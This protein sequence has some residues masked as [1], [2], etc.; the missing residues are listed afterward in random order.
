M[1]S[2][3]SATAQGVRRVS[4]LTIWGV[5]WPCWQGLGFIMGQRLEFV[6][7]HLYWA[8]FIYLFWRVDN[9]SIPYWQTR[10]TNNTSSIFIE[11]LVLIQFCLVIPCWTNICGFGFFIFF[12]TPKNCLVE[13]ASYMSV[14]VSV[15]S[16]VLTCGRFLYANHECWYICMYKES[17]PTLPNPPFLKFGTYL[18]SPGFISRQGMCKQSRSSAIFLKACCR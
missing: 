17:L 14:S 1:V 4:H 10:Y 9:K 12:P 11:L 13:N 3:W 7:L 2:L 18:F 5:K 15:F 8:V 16:H 6:P